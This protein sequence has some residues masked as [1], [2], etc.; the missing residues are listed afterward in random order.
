MPCALFTV[1]AA[2][3]AI[4]ALILA[5]PAPLLA[6]AWFRTIE[7]HSPAG[8]PTTI[9]SAKRM[10]APPPAID[11]ASD[12]RDHANVAAATLPVW[13]PRDPGRTLDRS[14]TIWYARGAWRCQRTDGTA[15]AI[16]GVNPPGLL[17][18]NASM[19]GR[20][21]LG[22]VIRTPGGAPLGR[23]VDSGIVLCR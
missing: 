13:R 12:V 18:G 7:N 19:S 9:D 17:Y 8:P 14:D 22:S 20:Q 15:G 3:C 2:G 23:L 21:S 16:I 1:R 6:Q 10:P 11:G 5:A 4:A